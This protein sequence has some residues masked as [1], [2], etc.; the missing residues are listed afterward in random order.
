MATRGLSPRGR[1]N[2]VELPNNADLAM[3][4][5]YPRVGG[6]TAIGVVPPRFRTP[7]GLSP[8]GRG[9]P[10]AGL[11][12]SCD[13][14]QRS[15]PAWAGEPSS[16]S[17][18]CSITIWPVYPRVGG[19]T[20]QRRVCRSAWVTGLSPRGRGNPR[21]RT[22]P[23]RLHDRSIPAWAGEPLRAHPTSYPPSVRSI[24]AWAGEPSVAEPR[25]RLA[26]VY[27]RVAGEPY[28][29]PGGPRGRRSIPAWAGEPTREHLVEA[30]ACGAVYPRVG[31]G[32]FERR[33]PA[34]PA[35]G[36]SPRGREP[37]CWRS[38]GSKAGRSIPAWAG[39]H[40]P[41]AV[42]KTW[43]GLSPR[44]RGNPHFENISGV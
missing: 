42:G 17:F 41:A 2:R 29:H 28:P 10:A 44:G 13:G 37:R 24:P 18:E 40:R 9:N 12:L 31:G 16:A 27:P 22:D 32:T 20:V 36:L 3:V 8:R 23:G 33:L 43:L 14:Q 35:Y 21:S 30:H 34:C 19:G 38:R 25:S 39:N 1:G 7:T 15:I 5:V 26:S 11:S 4:R 6:G